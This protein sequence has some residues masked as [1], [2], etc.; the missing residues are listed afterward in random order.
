MR[1]LRTQDQVSEAICKI[2]VIIKA[3]AISS[4]CDVPMCREAHR[5][6]P[7]TPPTREGEPRTPHRLRARPIPGPACA[8]APLAL[9]AQPH[10]EVPAVRA[11]FSRQGSV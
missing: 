4:V 9:T 3:R 2:K 7:P 6:I 11:S 10:S 1:W 8:S 5:A